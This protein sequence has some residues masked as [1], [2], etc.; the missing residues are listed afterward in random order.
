MSGAPGGREGRTNVRIE[1]ATPD[2]AQEILGVRLAA[3]AEGLG[4]RLLV[5]LGERGAATVDA[6]VATVDAGEVTV[7][8]NDVA[9]VEP[10]FS[11]VGVEV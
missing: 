7:T 2:D 6:S 5:T 4:V 9:T 10:E 8:E 11:P 1:P 3:F